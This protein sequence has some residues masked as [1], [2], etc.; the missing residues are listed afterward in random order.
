M[1]YLTNDP[2]YLPLMMERVTRM[3]QRDYNHP[4]IIIW[5]LGNESGYGHNHDAMYQWLKNTDPSRPIQYE[6]GGADT[7]A[8]DIIAPMYARVDQDQVE[9]VNSKWA[10]KKWI[11]LP[12]ENRPLILCEYAHSMGNSSGGFN[13]YWEAFEKYPRL[14]G[15][16]IWDW[17]DQACSQK[18]TKANHIMLMVVIL[19]IILM[20]ANLAW[21]GYYF[22]IA[23]QNQPCWRQ[24]TVNNISLSNWK[25]IQLEKLTI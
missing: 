18:I 15:G 20:I 2:K 5:S 6:G 25:K 11:G 17:V 23:L 7:P 21:M 4:S 8:T 16:F 22:P 13:K 12:K 19:V 14:Q 3:V 9:E 10:I 24:N 1:N